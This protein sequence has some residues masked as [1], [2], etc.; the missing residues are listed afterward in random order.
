MSA[1]KYITTF[2]SSE[3][4]H[5]AVGYISPNRYEAAWPRKTFRPLHY[6]WATANRGLALTLTLISSMNDDARTCEWQDM[7][8]PRHTNA[9]RHDVTIFG[10]GPAGIAAALQCSNAGMNTLLVECG[11]MLGGTTT[12][13]GVNFPGLFHAWGKQVIRGYGW[14]LVERCVR[15]CGET[16]PDFSVVPDRHWKHQVKVNRAVYAMLCDEALEQA[17]CHVRLFTMPAALEPD[18]ESWRV[19]VCG[20]TGIESIDTRYIIDCTGDA[21]VVALAGGELRVSEPEH[22]PGTQVCRVSGYDLKSL[23]MERINRNL[24]RAVESG[25]VRPH[26]VGWSASEPNIKGWLK[27]HGENVNHI[28]DINARDSAGRTQIQFAGRRSILRMYRFLKHQP[29]LEQLQID[30]L[31]PECGVRETA[32]IVGEDTVTVD[33]YCSGRRWDEA[34]CFSFYPVDLHTS[35]GTGLKKRY[36]EPGI[37]PTVPRG[38]LLPRGLGRIAAA[39]R[40]VS[41][42]REANS[43]LRVQASSMAMGQSAGA[44]VAVAARRNEDL[45]NADLDMIRE[46]LREHDA[47]V[48]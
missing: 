32:V 30:Y 4:K 48:P 29:G 23:D 41:S 11:S 14:Q 13:G 16:L 1:I 26:D 35:S 6:S 24:A 36:L 46:L 8:C 33:D 18:D 19:T 47:V 21:N 39:G 17:G 20:K 25:E 9:P 10:G 38:A 44:T 40:C 7:D 22:Q 45:R 28:P 31:A 43:A 12:V 27:N 34:L 37:V 15:E 5:Q 3:R 2:Y 42:D